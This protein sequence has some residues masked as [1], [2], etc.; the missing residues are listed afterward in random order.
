MFF[1]VHCVLC[2]LFSVCVRGR[3]LIGVFVLAGL[4]IVW[5]RIFA[6]HP[7][8]MNNNAEE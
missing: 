4:S 5:K 8:N 1:V 2:P 3:I 6:G 7:P